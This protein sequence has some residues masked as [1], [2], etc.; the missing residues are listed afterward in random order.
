MSSVT[1]A[2]AVKSPNFLVTCSM[3]MYAGAP[4]LFRGAF[5]SCARAAIRARS[6]TLADMRPAS[7]SRHEFLPAACHE[8]RALLGVPKVRNEFRHHL[9]RRVDTGIVENILVDELTCREIAVRVMHEVADGSDH[10][11]P[12]H[13]IDEQMGIARMW[14]VFRN[15][16]VVEPHDRALLRNGV[17]DLLPGLVLLRTTG[18]LQDVTVVTDRETHL[19]IG[20]I[21]NH[22]LRI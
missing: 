19:A 8:T 18:S 10:L 4:G 14:R 5:R 21:R 20:E 15:R 22:P 12:Q 6:S 3:R 9:R 7:V 16:I 2:T 11:R 13:V 1:W 17:R